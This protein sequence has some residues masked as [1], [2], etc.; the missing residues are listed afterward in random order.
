MGERSA[1]CSPAPELS[2]STDSAIVDQESTVRKEPDADS[3]V[4]IVGPALT[5]TKKRKKLKQDI[6]KDLVIINTDK[7]EIEKQ[8]LQLLVEDGHRREAEDNDADR[9][10]LLRLLPLLWKMPDEPKT[11]IKIGIHE[12]L[13]K[14]A[15][16]GKQVNEFFEARIEGQT[17]GSIYRPWLT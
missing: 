4:K 5:V 16:Q 1:R 12:A 6:D 8:N 2:T 13:N 14:V 10:I 3:C 9:H 17:T 15:F 7:L 11:V